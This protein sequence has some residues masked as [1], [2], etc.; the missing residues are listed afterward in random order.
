M[1]NG[2]S[3]LTVNDAFQEITNLLLLRLIEPKIIDGSIN[4]ILNQDNIAIDDQCIFST[5]Y[6]KYCIDYDKK[7]K[8]KIIK[9][10]ELYDLLF[11][12]NRHLNRYFDETLDAFIEKEDD[13]DY[14]NMCVFKK[15]Y[16]HKSLSEIYKTSWKKYFKFEKKMSLI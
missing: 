3:K 12:E 4:S 9:F 10:G 6:N 14:N 11:N 8:E 2:I 5:I 15:I 1:R 7:I 16:H 13:E